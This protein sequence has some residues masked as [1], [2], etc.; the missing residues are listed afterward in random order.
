VSKTCIG[1][2]ILTGSALLASSVTGLQTQAQQLNS[3]TPHGLSVGSK[4]PRTLG[5]VGNG[6]DW[7][8][9][10]A[11]GSITKVTGSFDYMDVINEFGLKDGAGNVVFPNT[12]MLQIN[13]T[14]LP[15]ILVCR[16]RNMCYVGNN[17]FF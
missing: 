5:V 3:A 7:F 16:G 12:Y 15:N 1:V 11:G 10:I 17:L 14:E 6:T 8:A 13:T 9:T 2:L 4:G